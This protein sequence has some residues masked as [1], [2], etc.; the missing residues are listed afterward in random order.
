[1]DTSDPSWPTMRSAPPLDAGEVHVWRIAL[2]LPPES[3]A[4]LA[5]LLA[6]EETVRAQRFYFER[7]RRRFS[8]ARGTLRS[9]LA[10][11]RGLDARAIR[12]AYGPQGKPALA[13]A[14]SPPVCFNLAHSHELALVALTRGLEVGTDVEHIRPRESA[15]G[16]VERYFAE[17]ERSALSQ[18]P[19]HEQQMAF[20]RCWT[21]KEA[22]MKALGTG[23]NLP[24]DSFDVSVT[25]EPLLLSAGGDVRQWSMI[26]VIPGPDYVGCVAVEG[27]ACKLLCWH[28]PGEDAA[29]PQP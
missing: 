2:D 21:R 1:M 26:E 15:E 19:P 10:L 16:I 8:V 22:Y 25:P 11:Y 14:G 29:G 7:D 13:E 18:V 24:L 9:L 6:P 5:E 3:V 27:G 28:W 17:R 23:L 20:Y 4:A 12:F